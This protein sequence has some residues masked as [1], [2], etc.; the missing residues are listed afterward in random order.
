MIPESELFAS[1]SELGRDW[2]AGVFTSVELTEFALQ[3]LETLGRDHNAVVTITRELALTQA[4]QA[5]AE[6]AAGVDRGPLHGLPYGAKDL[7]A[8]QGYPTTWG[9]APFREQQFETNATVITRLRDAGAVLVAKLAMIELAGGFGYRQAHASFT[10]PALNAW[11]KTRWGGGSSSGSGIAVGAGLVAFALGSE[12]SG[13]I[14]NPAGQNGV[15]GLRPTYGLVPRTGAMALSW[16]LDKVGPIARTAEDCLTIH[17]I[18]AGPDPHDFTIVDPAHHSP[19]PVD[20]TQRPRIG[21]IKGCLANVQPE[22]RERFNAVVEVL[23]EFAEIDTVALPD[24]P[25]GTV[26]GTI[27]NGEMAAA[28]EEFIRSG[29]VQEL[30]A[31]E[32]RWGGYSVLAVPAKDYI[33]ALRV[34]RKIQTTL[35]DFLQTTPVLIAPTLATVAGPIDR[36]FREWS[37]GFASSALGVAA[38]AAGLPGFTLPMGPGADGLPTA[39]QLVAGPLQEAFLT[40]IATEFQRR[41][42]WHRAQPTL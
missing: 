37:R 39:C 21:I 28:F 42:N 38:N 25:Y 33:N 31:P 30:T 12:T 6:R 4:A 15:T 40:H 16:T 29:R 22:V 34:R 9:A 18:I 27:I 13:S 35:A 10:G 1:L 7:F 3:R 14:M 36:D 8:V 17:K 26:V 24:L 20:L 23:R 19:W 11:D 32:D 41:T 5:D 2:R